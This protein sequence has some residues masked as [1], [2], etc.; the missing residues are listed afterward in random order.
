MKEPDSNRSVYTGRRVA[1]RRLHARVLWPALV[2]SAALHLLA[3]FF[4]G[5]RIDTSSELR[6]P[7]PRLLR[8]VP[9]MQ[10]YEIAVVDAEVPSI[11]AQLPEREKPVVEVTPIV[12]SGPA[13]G[14]APRAARE[15]LDPSLERLR[16]R[17]PRTDV[18]RRSDPPPRSGEEV[19]RERVAARLDAYNDSVAADAAAS[20]R[21]TDWTVKDADGGRWGVSPGAVHLGSITLPLPFTVAAAPGRREEFAGRV[22]TWNELQ[23]QA[24]RVEGKEVFDERVKAIRERLEKERAGRA[25]GN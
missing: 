2:V 7:P 9:V 21:A 20:A 23:D 5:F 3:L 8:I 4:V 14:I 16:Y 6:A 24:A 12:P 19:V 1:E 10:A 13:P 22:R 15:A 11:E 25:G 18:W 17:T